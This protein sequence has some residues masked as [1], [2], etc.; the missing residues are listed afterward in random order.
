MMTHAL[1]LGTALVLS[2]G[3][4]GGALALETTAPAAG[5]RNPASAQHS[6][7]DPAYKSQTPA[8]PDTDAGMPEHQMREK[9]GAGTQTPSA[10]GT[11][12]RPARSG[13]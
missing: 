1:R 12:N 2:M 7:S 6:E 3:L 5:A 8:T 13:G 10:P 11:A 4:C 9:L